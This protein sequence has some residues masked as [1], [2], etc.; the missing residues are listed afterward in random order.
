VPRDKL[1]MDGNSFG[2]N[3]YAHFSDGNR[4]WLFDQVWDRRLADAGLLSAAQNSI[5][6]PE[7]L[8]VEK[9]YVDRALPRLFALS[10][11]YS[12]DDW[13]RIASAT[14]ATVVPPSDAPEPSAAAKP[15]PDK[16]AQQSLDD[17]MG[18][19]KRLKSEPSK[20][21]VAASKAAPYAP[22]YSWRA[23]IDLVRPAAAPV[24]ARRIAS[25]DST[26]QATQR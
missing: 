2:A 1:V 17:L 12:R 21:D 5:S 6:L 19:L 13:R 23:A 15:K 8:S 24:G 26:I 10:S 3:L 4:V 9:A 18:E 25:A 16:P 22:A 20:P 14:G 11:R 7:G